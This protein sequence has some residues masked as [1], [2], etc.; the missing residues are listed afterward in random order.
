MWSSAEILFFLFAF[1]SR[2]LPQTT[3]LQLR[4]QPSLQMPFPPCSLLL[5]LVLLGTVPPARLLRSRLKSM[6]L[7][8]LCVMSVSVKLFADMRLLCPLDNCQL[9]FPELCFR[10]HGFLI[11]LMLM[12]RCNAVNDNMN[13]GRNDHT[14]TQ[15]TGSLVHVEMKCHYL[16]FSSSLLDLDPLSSSGPS[17][18]SAAPTSWG[19]KHLISFRSKTFH[20]F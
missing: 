16:I 5:L 14:H 18:P 9:L 8:N 15:T 11:I 6:C 12:N 13:P 4:P 19:G 2:A 1:S 3:S 7:Q 10:F 20:C 17:A